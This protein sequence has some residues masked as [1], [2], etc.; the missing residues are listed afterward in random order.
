MGLVIKAENDTK[1]LTSSGGLSC[2]SQLAHFIVF[3]YQSV[4]VQC[5]ESDFNYIGYLWWYLI[6]SFVSVVGG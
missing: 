5:A 6:E 3:F 2:K 4:V 1:L